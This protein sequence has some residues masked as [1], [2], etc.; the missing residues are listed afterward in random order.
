MHMPAARTKLK[1]VDF[2]WANGH[3][4]I[5]SLKFGVDRMEKS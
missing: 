3:R 2:A 4:T 5:G 1:L